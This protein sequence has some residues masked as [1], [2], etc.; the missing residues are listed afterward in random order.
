[1]NLLRYIFI[2]I[3]GHIAM[4]F[5]LFRFDY[6]IDEGVGLITR[7]MEEEGEGLGYLLMTGTITKQ[8]FLI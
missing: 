4:S 3:L 6:M 8:R 5:S 1:M 2:S 7:S